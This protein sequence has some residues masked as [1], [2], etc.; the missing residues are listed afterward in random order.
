M[1]QVLERFDK[2][3]G[4]QEATSDFQEENVELKT[5]KPVRRSMPGLPAE[6]WIVILGFLS[7][8]KHLR[9][10]VHSCS[11]LLSL[12]YVPAPSHVPRL[13]L[14]FGPFVCC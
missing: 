8:K 2:A 11:Y 13:C 9:A 4:L 14:L 7:D 3:L 12:W 5:D 10:A 1:E 6:V